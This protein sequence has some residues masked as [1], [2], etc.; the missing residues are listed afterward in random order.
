MGEY[1]VFVGQVGNASTIKLINN[2]LFVANTIALSEAY[3]LGEK[4]GINSN[5]CL[6]LLNEVQV[7]QSR[8]ILFGGIRLIKV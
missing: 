6:T 7:I 4:A 5:I 2:M 3:S 8:L 1:V